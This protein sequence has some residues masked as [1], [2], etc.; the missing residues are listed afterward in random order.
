M[1]GGLVSTV[2]ILVGTEASLVVIGRVAARVYRR[3]VLR[4]RADGRCIFGRWGDV[5]R[6]C[7]IIL[8]WILFSIY[9]V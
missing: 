8:M 6:Y 5:I 9:D 1:L 7:W 4:M 2:A 3:A